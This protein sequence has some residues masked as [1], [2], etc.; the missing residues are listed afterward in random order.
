MDH[1]SFNQIVVDIMVIFMILGGF[2]KITKKKF[3]LGL[4]DEFEE[5]FQALG[6]L[7]LSMLGILAFA[8]V[9]DQNSPYGAGSCL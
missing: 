3:K 9:T 6:A 5:G 1:F 2:D 7:A 4:A 8:P